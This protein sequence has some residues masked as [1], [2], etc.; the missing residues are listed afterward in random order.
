V[1]IPIFLI[2]NPVSAARRRKRYGL[3]AD[4]RLKDYGGFEYRTLGSWLISPKIALAV[5]CL[6]K[7]V[8]NHY[9]ELNEN[10]LDNYESQS[11][12]YQGNQDYFRLIFE[13]LWSDIYS[14]ETFSKYSSDLKIIFDMVTNSIIWNE[15]S[16]LR[17]VWKI[18]GSTKRHYNNNQQTT[19]KSNS[20]SRRMGTNNRSRSLIANQS[21]SSIIDNPI[22]NSP[23]S[24][25][26]AAGQMNQLNVLNSTRNTR[27]MQ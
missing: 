23:S 20:T 18:V 24:S 21:N 4:Y 12:F 22:P 7:V 17:E 11:A 14:T 15:K 3:L 2:E 13:R 19:E 8:A 5:L 9:L 25:L 16:D 10:Y 27:I 26:L 1:G 6:A